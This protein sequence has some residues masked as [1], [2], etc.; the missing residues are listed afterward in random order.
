M[1][2]KIDIQSDETGAEAPKEEQTPKGAT[3]KEDGQNTERP[4]WLPEKFDTP[5]A[6]AKAYGELESKV[7]QPKEETPKPT[8]KEG[9]LTINEEAADKAV[10]K[11]G[12]NMESLSQEYAEKGALEDKSYTALEKAGIPKDYVDAFIR[13][14]QAIATQTSNAIK[15]EVGGVEAYAEM[16]QWASDNLN[17]AEL[18][19]YNT[20]VNG[21]DIEA[22]KLAV[23][24]LNARYKTSTG[25]EPTLNKGVK[26]TSSTGG[27]YRSWAEVT[28]AM[29]DDK[30]KKDDAYRND[31]QSKLK[32]SK[33]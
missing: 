2:E 11:A 19:S 7:G 26:T 10:Q 6:M 20:T 28:R 9:D 4:E 27:S 29:A 18:K 17:E 16:V 12:L 31:V 23:Q 1:V 22:V 15:S 32:N 24:G 14:Q 25:D 8:E 13:G 3:L 5:E 21:K 30:Y 33:L